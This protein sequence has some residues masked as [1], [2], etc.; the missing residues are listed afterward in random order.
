MIEVEGLTGGLV[1][2]AACGSCQGASCGI[3]RGGG[4]LFSERGGHR[5]GLDVNHPGVHDLT[6]DLHH[7]LIVPRGPPA[8]QGLCEK[9]GITEEKGGITERRVN[10]AEVEREEKAM[11]T[12][13]V[14]SGS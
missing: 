1:R 5:G 2:L 11:V 12:R 14:H 4:R 8:R 10:K 9:G 7:L 6:L 3:A 13:W